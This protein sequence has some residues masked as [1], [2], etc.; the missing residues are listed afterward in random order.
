M[1]KVFIFCYLLVQVQ[2]SCLRG[3][4]I[5]SIT[6]NNVYWIK[7]SFSYLYEWLRFWILGVPVCFYRSFSDKYIKSN[8]AQTTYFKTFLPLSCMTNET[9]NDSH[10]TTTFKRE[11]NIRWGNYFLE[12]LYFMPWRCSSKLH[13]IPL[14]YHSSFGSAIQKWLKKC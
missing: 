7:F 12:F 8:D 10:R 6:F 13:F 3:T 9:M 2:L 1:K 14:N 5:I 4:W 11:K